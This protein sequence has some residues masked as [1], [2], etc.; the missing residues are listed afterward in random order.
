MELAAFS[1]VEYLGDPRSIV[2]LFADGGMMPSP[3]PYPAS[4]S[5]YGGT[6]AFCGID[7]TG[8]V[9]VDG[10]GFIPAS[11]SG[12]SLE[13]VTNNMS[14][15]AAAGAALEVIPDGYSVWLCLDSLVTISR[16]CSGA[17]TNGLPPSWVA[18]VQRRKDALGRIR[19]L[20]LKGHPSQADLLAGYKIVDD[21]EMPVSSFNVYV[22]AL[23]NL[24]KR[25]AVERLG[26]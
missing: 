26:L 1:E 15:Y 25:I 14:E 13:T 17:R 5:P 24:A 2:A 7:I 21:A 10:Y 19:P 9:I 12:G 11:L 22:D 8:K 16:I 23:C 6:W 18:K 3:K 20:L 4:R